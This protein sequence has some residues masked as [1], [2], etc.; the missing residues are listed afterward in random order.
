M[1]NTVTRNK[2]WQHLYDQRTKPLKELHTV[3]VRVRDQN[4]KKWEPAIVD[5]Q[6][7]EP[8]SYIVSAPS[9]AQYRRNRRHIRTTGESFRVLPSI[10]DN[11]GDEAVAPCVDN[12]D[13]NPPVSLPG[14][15]Y[16]SFKQI[17]KTNTKQ[18]LAAVASH[19]KDLICKTI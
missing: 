9:G 14:P 7:K 3:T 19:L 10:D 18:G 1:K 15:V 13:T 12:A 11:I 5:R 2:K 17:R 16:L 8:R 6:S 4:T